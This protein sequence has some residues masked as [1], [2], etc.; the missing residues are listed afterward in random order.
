LSVTENSSVHK[1]SDSTFH[2]LVYEHNIS[3]VLYVYYD[4]I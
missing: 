3:S 2:L 4:A 1:L